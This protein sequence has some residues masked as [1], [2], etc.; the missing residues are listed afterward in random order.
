MGIFKK[1]TGPDLTF[2]L[3]RELM[4]VECLLGASCPT[5]HFKMLINP[6]NPMKGI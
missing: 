2:K 3:S 6:L 5:E 1:V 4:I